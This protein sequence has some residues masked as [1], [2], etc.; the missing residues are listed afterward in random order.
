MPDFALPPEI[1]ELRE[2][3]ARFADRELVPRVRD[4]EAAG[5]WPDDVL[6]VL[7]GFSLRTLDLP[8]RLG[9]APDGCLAK[10]VVLETI[11]MG[12]AG[13]L[14]SV[15]QP[16]AAAGALA[17][18]PDDA[19][20]GDVA[21]AC[22]SGDASCALVVVDPESDGPPRIEWAPSWPTLQYVWV[23]EGDTLALL[24]TPAETQQTTALALQASGGVSLAV[25]RRRPIGRWTLPHGGGLAVRAR[26]RLWCAAIA[27]GVAQ[28]AFDATVVYTTDRVVF[29]KAVAHHQA[30]AFELA[31]AATE[32]HGARLAVRDAA[33]RFDASSER[34]GDVNGDPHAGYWATQAWITAMDAGVRATD[35]GIQ[36]LGGHGFLVDHLAEKRFREAGMLRLLFGG[37]DAAD[38]D[39]AANALLVP[40]P[41]F[42]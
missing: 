27:V 36:L 12:D 41:I 35:L 25:D 30:N 42:V 38:A 11:A 19:V 17:A 33:R 34:S 39:L 6:S 8:H 24:D 32:V 4:H 31:A 21:A 22:L 16:G 28:A 5:R 3:A 40:D 23:I 29:G 13:G 37:R 1:E 2:A 20:A 14:P 18:C 9:G 10:A 15:D 7:D 26:A